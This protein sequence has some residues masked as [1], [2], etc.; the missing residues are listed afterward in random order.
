MFIAPLV[1][2]VP[3]EAAA[4]ALI[5]VGFLMFSQLRKIDWKDYVIGIPAFLTIV[6][7]PFTYSIANGIGAGFISYALLM[8]VTGKAKKVGWLMWV[9]AILFLIFFMQ[10]PIRQWFGLG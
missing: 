6:I 7:M 3:Y 9:V 1:T 2:T 5:V 4:P 8:T 10:T